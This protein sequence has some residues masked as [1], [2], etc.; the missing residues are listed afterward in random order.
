LSKRH[1]NLVDEKTQHLTDPEMH[2]QADEPV[3]IRKN[4][5]EKRLKTTEFRRP[6]PMARGPHRV[7]I[8]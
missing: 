2:G 1:T 7:L 4:L 3:T 6:T 8:F 5:N